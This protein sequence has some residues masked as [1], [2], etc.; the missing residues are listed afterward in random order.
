[1]VQLV[2]VLVHAAAHS[3]QP[4]QAISIPVSIRCDEFPAGC[5]ASAPG[6]VRAEPLIHGRCHLHVRDE[7]LRTPPLRRAWFEVPQL[8]GVPLEPYLKIFLTFM[9]ILGEL[10]LGQKTFT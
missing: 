9:G 10:Y 4:C 6:I 5:A 2:A 7:R 1:M 3:G 8:P